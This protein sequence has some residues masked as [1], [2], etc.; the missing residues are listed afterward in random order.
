MINTCQSSKQNGENGEEEKK[1]EEYVGELI[2]GQAG[3]ND[4][5]SLLNGAG[6]DGENGYNLSD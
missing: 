5:D 1:E 3:P 2:E 6:I 4:V